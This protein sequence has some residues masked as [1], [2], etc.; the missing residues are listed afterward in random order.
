MNE[1]RKL[2]PKNSPLV[3]YALKGLELCWLPEFGR[4]SHIYH[5][6]KRDPPNDPSPKVTSF[7]RLMFSWGWHM[8]GTYLEIMILRRRSSEV[9]L[10]L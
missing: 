8:S 3:E 6:D 10:N 1:S 5:L 7:I 2:G 9:P 4:W